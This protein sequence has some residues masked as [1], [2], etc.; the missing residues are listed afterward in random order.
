MFSDICAHDR[1]SLW[2]E[3]LGRIKPRTALE[4]GVWK[5]EFA[6]HMLRATPSI[7]RY[8]MID[9]WRRLDHWNKPLN[10]EDLEHAY[11][12]AL[13][14]TAFAKEKIEVLRGT[15]AERFDQIPDNSLDLIYV[16]GDHTLRGVAIDL[17]CIYS[18]LKPGG[19][20]GGDDFW[21]NIWQHGRNFEP[22]LVFP[23]VVY[24]AEA[25]GA[26]LWALDHGQFIMQKP[27]GRRHFQFHDAKSLYVQTELLPLIPLPRRSNV[28]RKVANKL[29]RLL[30]RQ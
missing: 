9:P 1:I 14:A 26:E 18:K 10:T 2:I 29:R 22:T 6:A 24:F 28:V 5:G 11:Q 16:D 27:L 21:P 7:I 25:M 30:T 19:F 17:V 13:R 20:L 4:V 8:Y 3:L 23:F 15:T 12:E